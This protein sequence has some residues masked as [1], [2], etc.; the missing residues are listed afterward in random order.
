MITAHSLPARLAIEHCVHEARGIDI[1][2]Q[3]ISRFRAGG[4]VGSADLLE[5]VIY[6]EEISHCGAGVRWLKYLYAQ[7]SREAEVVES[8]GGGLTEKV[9]SNGGGGA[10]FNTTANSSSSTNS[11]DCGVVTTRADWAVDA[12]QFPSVE[13]WFHAL[14]RRHFHG[15]LKPPF[16]KEARAKAGFGEEWYLPLSVKVD[17]HKI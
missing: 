7:A 2:P 13:E 11:V 5:H 8:V 15:L 6:A 14:V 17:T 16:N 4:D 9:E 3:T 10:R 1:L 12:A